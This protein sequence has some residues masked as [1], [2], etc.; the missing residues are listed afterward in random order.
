MIYDHD[1]TSLIELAENHIAEISDILDRTQKNHRN[2]RN[3]NYEEPN[4]PLQD[5]IWI[6]ETYEDKLKRMKTQFEIYLK[7]NEE[8]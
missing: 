5:M 3:W 8:T 6:L 7:Y 2:L 4:K 1:T